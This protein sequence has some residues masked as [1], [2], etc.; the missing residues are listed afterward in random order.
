MLEAWLPLAP[1]M[2]VVALEEQLVDLEEHLDTARV[3][4]DSLDVL[5]E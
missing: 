2:A 1:V 3:A 4:D 5:C